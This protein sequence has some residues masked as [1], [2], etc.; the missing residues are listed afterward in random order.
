MSRKLICA[1]V[2][3]ALL[4]AP[5]QAND[6]ALE[7]LARDG[8]WKRL[9]AAVE[10]RLK[11]NP[12][13]AEA[14]YY[15]AAV[16]EAF[17]DLAGAL[18]LAEKALQ[19]DAKNS[20]YHYMVGAIQGQM[21]EKAGV[22][23]AMGLVG[24]FKKE[25]QAAIDLDPNNI[26]ALFAQMEFYLQAPGIVGGDK[27]KARANA[28]RIFAINPSRG[29]LAYARVVLKENP[30]ADVANYFVNAVQADPR[31]YGARVQLANFY[32][33][34]R[35]KKYDLSEQEAREA[36]KANPGRVGAYSLL[37]A[38]FALQERWS[39]LDAIL[40][41]S[42]KNVPDNLYPYYQAGR[43]LL[44]SGK[45]LPRAERYLR[46]YLTQ[47]PEAG[48]PSHAATHWRLGLVYEKM[49]RKAEAIAEIQTAV[50]LD[51]KFEPAQKDLKRLK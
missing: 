35:Q 48:A 16:R 29:N 37:A 42:E 18:P 44:G 50:R 31:S 17:N 2:L 36:L 19:L 24:R 28:D 10:P 33:S 43:V 11:A 51:P 32:A 23:K 22:F 1:V 5:L 3:L 49:G 8:H 26:E 14:N 27:K 38:L 9:R 25:V 39:D 34:D 46:K 7:S 4:A 12:N 13:D 45:D 21:A 20:D 41:Q 47:E 6:P 15:M 40:V 30:R